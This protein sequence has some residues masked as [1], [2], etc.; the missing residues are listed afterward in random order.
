MFSKTQIII[1][2]GS[3]TLFFPFFIIMVKH[4]ML[5]RLKRFNSNNK[6]NIDLN[7]LLY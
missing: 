2:N 5:Q 4:K 1:L 3:K 7:K 6:C